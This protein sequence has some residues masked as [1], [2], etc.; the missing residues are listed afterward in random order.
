MASVH[1]KPVLDAEEVQAQMLA[2]F[3]QSRPHVPI[4]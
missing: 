1:G 2:F 4:Q 3:L